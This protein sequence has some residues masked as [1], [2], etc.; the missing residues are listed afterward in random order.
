MP[1]ISEY[2]RPFLTYFTGFVDELVGLIIPIFVWQSPTG[3]CYGNHAVKFGGWSQTSPGTTFP[4][5]GV[6]ERIGRNA[7]RKS[8]S[9]G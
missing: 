6:R 4:L 8:A 2:P 9:K 1:N 7:D 5:L 3:R